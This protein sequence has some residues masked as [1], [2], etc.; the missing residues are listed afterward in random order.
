MITALSS[1]N[2]GI[3]EMEAAGQQIFDSK[4]CDEVHVFVNSS[5]LGRV[6]VLLSPNNG[7]ISALVSVVGNRVFWLGMTE[8]AYMVALSN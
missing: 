4:R 8:L 7:Q 1:N 6:L 2:W 5:D 3:I